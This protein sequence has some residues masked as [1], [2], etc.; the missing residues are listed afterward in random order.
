MGV[1]VGNLRLIESNIVLFNMSHNSFLMNVY[2]GIEFLGNIEVQL[3][4]IPGVNANTI[5]VANGN[6]SLIIQG[7]NLNMNYGCGTMEPIK[8]GVHNGKAVSIH[9]WFH[10]LDNGVMRRVEYNIYMEN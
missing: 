10:A 8:I 1:T 3:L 4:N 7:I 2:D 9:I 6:N 5:R